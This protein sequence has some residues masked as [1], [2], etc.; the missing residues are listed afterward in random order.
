MDTRV[1][2]LH[3]MVISQTCKDGGGPIYLPHLV[4]G[5]TAR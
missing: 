5:S 4:K 2:M 3:H 1:P